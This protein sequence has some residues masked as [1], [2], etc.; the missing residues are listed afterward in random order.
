MKTNVLML[1]NEEQ[2]DMQA[3]IDKEGE[4]DVSSSDDETP[5]KTFIDRN[6]DGIPDR[7]VGAGGTK[8]SGMTGFNF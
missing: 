7:P 2:R 4:S 1:T 5:E 3:Q 8:T 6:N